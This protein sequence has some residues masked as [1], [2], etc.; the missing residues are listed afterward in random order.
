MPLNILVGV[1]LVTSN[2]LEDVS[3]W[4]LFVVRRHITTKKCGK[5]TLIWRN[6]FG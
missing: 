6:V 1:I 5:E 3:R 2:F 4:D